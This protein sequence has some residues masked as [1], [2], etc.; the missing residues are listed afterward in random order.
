MTI[1]SFFADTVAAAIREARA[2]LGEE[3]MLL[4]SRR[5]PD[6]ASTSDG[7]PEQR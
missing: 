7:R 5:A 6:E 1:K 4:K 3:A 2:E